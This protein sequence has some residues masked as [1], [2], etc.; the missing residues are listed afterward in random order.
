MTSIRNV[1]N[2]HFI[3]EY[4][5]LRIE[6]IKCRFVSTISYAPP[7]NI[8]IIY[9]ILNI[10]I[11]E[12]FLLMFLLKP[13][14]GEILVDETPLSMSNLRNWQTSIAHVPQT[15]YLS[16]GTIAEN[17]A[18]GVSRDKIEMNLVKSVSKQAKLFDFIET[19]EAG[20][21]SMVG[22]RG[23][24]LS[25]GQKQ[26]IGI[27]RALYKKSSVLILDEATSALDSNTEKQIIDVLE[28]L[29][30]DLTIIMI[31]H[32]TTTLRTCDKIIEVKNKNIYELG[33]YSDFINSN[34]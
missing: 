1:G 14:T 33:D 15:I 2:H 17:I 21:D 23:V 22:E 30:E 20:F 7:I 27:A 26:R 19:L 4:F 25:G 9:E 16:D 28:G 13:T 29:S 8:D 31:A 11:V 32:R 12:D 34:H 10:T 18:F 6:E 24:K 3:H 5:Y